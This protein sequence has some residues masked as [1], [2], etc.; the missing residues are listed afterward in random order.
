MKKRETIKQHQNIQLLIIN[1]FEVSFSLR[2]LKAVSV[3]PLK[4]VKINSPGK[5]HPEEGHCIAKKYR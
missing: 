5:Y 4:E 1:L 2:Q 3:M